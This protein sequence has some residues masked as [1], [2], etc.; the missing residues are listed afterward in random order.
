[1][2]IVVLGAGGGGAEFKSVG[3]EEGTAEGVDYRA[4]GIKDSG[5][6]GEGVGGGEEGDGVLGIVG[7]V[8]CK[9]RFG[10]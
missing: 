2:P 4:G 7:V 5:Y 10:E 8:S 1:M 6:A 3:G 9:A